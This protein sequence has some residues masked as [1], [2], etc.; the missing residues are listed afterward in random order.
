MASFS[1][2]LLTDQAMTDEVRSLERV[3]LLKSFFLEP[4]LMWNSA[5]GE[6]TL[7]CTQSAVDLYQLLWGYREPAMHELTISYHKWNSLL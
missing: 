5:G 3:N 1:L 6:V 2:R 4:I 7:H